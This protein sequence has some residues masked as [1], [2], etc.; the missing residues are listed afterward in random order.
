MHLPRAWTIEHK[1]RGGTWEGRTRGR[2]EYHRRSPSKTIPIFFQN[3]SERQKQS[4]RSARAYAE[5]NDASRPTKPFHLHT[6]PATS[7]FVV[8]TRLHGQ[9]RKKKS[10]RS[11]RGKTCDTYCNFLVLA[12]KLVGRLCPGY[13]E[14]AECRMYMRHAH[15]HPMVV[16]KAHTIRRC[17][18]IRQ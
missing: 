4:R 1:E 18:S 10:T 15:I 6:H 8:S 7:P 17:D 9:T 14:W 3:I 2:K 11:V 12:F 16:Q 13:S 5:D